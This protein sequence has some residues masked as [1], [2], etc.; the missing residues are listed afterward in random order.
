[1]QLLI[2]AGNTRIKW[3]LADIGHVVGEWHAMGSI[4]HTDLEKVMQAW[5]A[6]KIKRVLISNVAGDAVA[7]QLRNI[8][9]ELNVPESS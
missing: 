2:D 4:V 5:S 1:M 7:S 3:A 6:H 8:L 9:V